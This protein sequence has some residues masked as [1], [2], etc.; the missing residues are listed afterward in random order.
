[1]Q[2]FYKHVWDYLNKRTYYVREMGAT[3]SLNFSDW[4][5]RQYIRV[6]ISL[7]YAA[8]YGDNSL[9]LLSESSFCYVVTGFWMP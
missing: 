7:A 6:L 5:R 9:K 3:F 1:M 4:E 2:L 8:M